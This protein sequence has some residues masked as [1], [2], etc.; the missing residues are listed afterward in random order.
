MS[1]PIPEGPPPTAEGLRDV[2]LQPVGRVVVDPHLVRRL[3]MDLVVT[4]QEVQMPV[5]S[6]TYTVTMSPGLVPVAQRK[7]VVPVLL[8]DNHGNMANTTVEFDPA[9]GSVTQTTQVPIEDRSVLGG[10]D[11]GRWVYVLADPGFSLAER[12]E[13]N[14]LARAWCY[15]I[16]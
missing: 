13:G 1:N 11:P 12:N 10:P 3:K 4:A 16:G 2:M 8:I 14:N 6:C 15:T 9:G 5:E 7:M